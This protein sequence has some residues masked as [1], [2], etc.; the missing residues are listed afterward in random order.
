[1]SKQRRFDRSLSLRIDA[2]QKA[3]D[4]AKSWAPSDTKRAALSVLYAR[5]RRLEKRVPA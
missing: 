2:I 4:T 5:L 3:I 1:M